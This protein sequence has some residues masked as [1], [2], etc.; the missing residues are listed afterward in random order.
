MV[1]YKITTDILQSSVLSQSIKSELLT[2]YFN[3][4]VSELYYFV[5]A[6]C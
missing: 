4:N 5:N 2:H 6:N 1:L 3:V